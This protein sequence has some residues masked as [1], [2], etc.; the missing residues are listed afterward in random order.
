MRLP[1]DFHEIDD[2]GCKSTGRFL[3]SCCEGLPNFGGEGHAADLRRQFI[4]DGKGFLTQ[5]LSAPSIQPCDLCSDSQ[6]QFT[7]VIKPSFAERR[8]SDIHNSTSQNGIGDVGLFEAIEASI[9]DFLLD[10]FRQQ[11][12]CIATK[13]LGFEDGH[14]HAAYALYSLTAQHVTAATEHSDAEQEQE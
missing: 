1:G 13:R 11:V 12:I 9:P 6:L 5:N 2:A 3:L 14:M 4:P 7:G 8:F 10:G